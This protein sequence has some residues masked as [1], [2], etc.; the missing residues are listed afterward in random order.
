MPS[1]GIEAAT[2]TG[3][4]EE[5][6]RARWPAAPQ[7]ANSSAAKSTYAALRSDAFPDVRSALGT[8]KPV[9]GVGVGV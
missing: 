1:S 3:G 8:S 7:G 4:T 2:S 6:K 5:G 9:Y